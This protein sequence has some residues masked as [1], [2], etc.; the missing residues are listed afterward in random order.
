M[1][2]V[3]SV[4]VQFVKFLRTEL[5]LGSV[6]ELRQQLVEDRTRSLRILQETR[7]NENFF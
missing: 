6:N 3:V 5:K 4:S 7:D 2:D 1:N